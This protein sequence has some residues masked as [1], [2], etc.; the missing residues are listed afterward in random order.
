M[1]LGECAITEGRTQEGVARLDDAMCSV[2]AGELTPL[3][4]GLVFCGVLSACFEIADLR[5][6]AEWT[7]A[8][9]AWCESIPSGSPYHGICR[10][11]R[12]EVT[13]LQG[14]WVEAETQAVR[15]SEE[16]LA[17]EPAAASEA[18]YAIGEIRRR[19]GDL[20]GAEAAFVRAHQ[21][22]RSPQPGLSLLRL[23]QD[24][25]GRRDG[26][27][28]RCSGRAAARATPA[29]NRPRRAGR[30]RVGLSVT[31]RVRRRHVQ[32]SKPS[33]PLRRTR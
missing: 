8:A 16:L 4:M 14:D 24:R 12:V 6:A 27:A 20:S 2:I 1:N 5:R 3:F 11:H 19:R 22:G 33:Q 29:R 18:F 9:V 32:R 21:L 28:P 23:R 17:L 26:V 31:R 15:A 7:S 10:V 13:T 25:V 30:S